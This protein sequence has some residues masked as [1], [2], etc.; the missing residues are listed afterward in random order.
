MSDGYRQIIISLGEGFGLR[1]SPLSLSRSL[2]V[3]YNIYLFIF[4]KIE[5]KK[6]KKKNYVRLSELPPS[7]MPAFCNKFHYTCIP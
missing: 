1:L 4:S 5:K 3:A 6:K 2:T 7:V